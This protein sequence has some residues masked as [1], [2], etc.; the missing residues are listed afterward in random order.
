MVKTISISLV[1]FHSAHKIFRVFFYKYIFELI[2]KIICNE[3][4]EFRRLFGRLLILA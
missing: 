2:F 3:M 4:N 1:S